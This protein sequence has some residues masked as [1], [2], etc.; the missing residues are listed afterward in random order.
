MQG[1]KVYSDKKALP[2]A[3]RIKDPRVRYA[4]MWAAAIATVLTLMPS[5]FNVRAIESFIFFFHIDAD[6][7]RE[8]A[9]AFL[10]GEN[11]YTQ[12]YQVG[13][14]QLPFTYPPIAAALFVPLGIIPSN[15]AGIFLTF[16]SAALLW[17][18][19]AI[20]AR[21]IIK[22]LSDSDY[23]LLALLILPL[24]LSTEPVFQTIQFGQVN[25]LLMAMVLMDTFTKKP[26]LPRGFWIGLAAAIK[27]TPAVF[28]L[29]FL[30]KKDWKGAA[31][32]I[33]S[34][35]GFSALAFLLLPAS[36]KIYWTEVLSDPSR[37]GNLSY[38]T[39][40]SV[41]GMFS[42][43]MHESQNTVEIIWMAA[44]VLCLVGVGFAMFRA[45]KAGA[46][47]GAL[48][49]NSLIALLC[50]PVSWSHHWVWLVPLTVAFA[51]SAWQQRQTAPATAATSAVLAAL[52]MIPM[53]VPTFWNMPYDSEA[54]PD[55]PL[56]LQ[57]SGNSYVVVA[58][59]IVIVSIIN[60]GIFGNATPRSTKPNPAVSVVLGI[61]ALFLLANVWFKGNEH[62]EALIQYPDNLLAGRGV[63]AFGDLILT[64][65]QAGSSTLALFAIG[66]I[67]L[68]ALVWSVAL[69]LKRYVE[70]QP[71]ALSVSA[72]VVFALIT[73]PVQHA[74]QLGSLS[75]LALALVL[76]DFFSPRPLGRR[77]V[78][79]GIAAG[80]V[81]WP[82]LI[83]VG[84]AI[85]RRFAPA[86]TATLTAVLLWA[87]GALANPG[88]R[89]LN[90]LREWFSVRDGAENLSPFGFIARWISDSPAAMF[91]WFG[92]ALV[93]GGFAIH[94]TYND[95]HRMLSNSLAIALPALA[96]PT[97]QLHHLVVLIPL[98]IALIISRRA[99]L[100]Y[101]GL[102]ILFVSWT[103]SH[104]SY[105]AV[106]PLN[107]PQPAG[108]VAH[109]GWYALVEP[110]AL[111][112][113]AIVVAIFVA[114]ARGNRASTSSRI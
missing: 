108:Y 63:T 37:I 25:I 47:H 27:L 26:W 102:F 98:V 53:L 16:I 51:A 46:P 72:A 14:I 90:L 70:I 62:N 4:L 64:P 40:Q 85:Q 71:E 87:I 81:G 33:A 75:L 19:I 7:Y 6:V 22:G 13:G 18:C 12:D 28:G 92:V 104:L 44:V 107:D 50:S 96:L 113:A 24:A 34:G 17:W 5:V 35:I 76:A 106:F 29:Y 36:S 49:L 38:I 82:V 15:V 57:P 31:V 101:L 41:R 39:N 95:E 1:E 67:N 55:W 66:A 68:A 3:S 52:S 54:A 97:V 65:L 114:C 9:K 80:I 23:R 8:G 74:L 48:L 99:L 20:V 91:I 45:V 86:A 77:G 79:T 110:M 88:A 21:R 84:F 30:V 73:F 78:L 69:V 59:A 83:I 60:P 105:G 93:I 89:N 94:R 61:T 58:I 103:P 42:R 2:S 11:L 111:A 109:F 100:G 43:L 32:S 112:P 56:L 10:R